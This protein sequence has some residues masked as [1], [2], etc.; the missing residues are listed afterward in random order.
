MQSTGFDFGSKKFYSN[1]SSLASMNRSEL[2]NMMNLS[3][4]AFKM[5]KTNLMKELCEKTHEFKRLHK[6]SKV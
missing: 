6:I 4:S 5:S 2:E 1:Q 3:S